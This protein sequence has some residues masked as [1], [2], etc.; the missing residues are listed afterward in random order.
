M[1]ISFVQNP[2]SNTNFGQSTCTRISKSPRLWSSLSSDL[3][4]TD[5]MDNSKSQIK[6]SY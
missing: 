2:G 4:E 1:H 6:E 5:E 3:R